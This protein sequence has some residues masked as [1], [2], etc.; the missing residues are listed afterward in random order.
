MNY[1]IVK[2]VEVE[3]DIDSDEMARALDLDL[4]LLGDL[5]AQGDNLQALENLK[6]LFPALVR[7]P[8]SNTKNYS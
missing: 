8:P 3:V 4:E 5:I 2:E 7:P 6:R 1:S